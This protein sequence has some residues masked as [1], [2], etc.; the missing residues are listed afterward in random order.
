MRNFMKKVVAFVL[1]TAMTIPT[2]GIS[3]RAAEYI[4][5]SSVTFNALA[6]DT[7]A[8][9]LEY[10]A[11]MDQECINAM[12][13]SE[14]EGTVYTGSKR[15]FVKYS[16]TEA[17]DDVVDI[18]VDA[19]RGCTVYYNMNAQKEANF[20]DGTDVTNGDITVPSKLTGYQDA[21]DKTSSYGA[22]K[23]T[24][25]AD[26]SGVTSIYVLYDNYQTDVTIRTITLKYG[27]ELPENY[28]TVGTDVT[29]AYTASTTATEKWFDKSIASADNS[30]GKYILDA[31]KGKK[32]KLTH[33]SAY[34]NG[35]GGFKF[36]GS[37]EYIDSWDGTT[38]ELTQIA[39]QGLAYDTWKTGTI[40]DS[41]PYR[42][43][44]MTL[45]NEGGSNSYKDKAYEIVL[46]GDIFS[47]VMVNDREHEFTDGQ[48]VKAVSDEAGVW[49]VNDTPVASG[50][51]LVYTPNAGDV[52]T[53]R[54]DETVKSITASSYEINSFTTAKI[55]SGN[56]K[57]TLVA[58][59]DTKTYVY[60]TSTEIT[61]AGQ[62]QFTVE[63]MPEGTSLTSAE[64]VKES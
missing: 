39:T 43:I 61:V 51:I 8:A 38:T 33:V 52:V 35:T 5:I 60:N 21:L 20:T 13:I 12:V 55:E 46:G 30:R 49:Y 56:Y 24:A 42:Y 59:D 58:S 57:I 3:A 2:I 23:Y 32:V 25:G 54:A 40:S 34:G 15:A 26:L 62:Y 29:L 44:Y 27:Y 18:T 63:G 47:Y 16:F 6:S 45:D 31:G 48:I 10:V 50:K 64:L 53:F 1:A 36:W 11:A 7:E 14:T 9:K 17:L 41:T 22:V 37:D 28:L 4:P 19:S